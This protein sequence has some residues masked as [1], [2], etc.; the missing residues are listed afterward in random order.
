METFTCILGWYA[1][2]Y[3]VSF[4]LGVAISIKEWSEYPSRGDYKLSDLGKVLALSTI[5][6]VFVI[7]VVFV[8]LC[9]LIDWSSGK[10]GGITLIKG[11]REENE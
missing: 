6:W 11:N 7:L 2:G 10:L 3:A 4:A 8:N 9:G 5:S 1:I